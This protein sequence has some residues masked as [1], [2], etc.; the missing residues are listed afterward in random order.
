MMASISIALCC[1]L[2]QP[3]EAIRVADR[4]AEVQVI[5]AGWGIV[6]ITVT[7]IAESGD[8]RSARDS[9]SLVRRTWPEPVLRVRTTDANRVVSTAGL[10]VRVIGKPLSIRV[11]GREGRLIQHLLVDE[12]T[13][14]VRF[15][16]GHGP[17]LGLGQGGERF[18]RRGALWTMQA[19][20]K[21]FT[22][23]KRH[24]G[25]WMPVPYLIGTDGWAMF[26]DRPDVKID[27]RGDR[28]EVIPPAQM[29][30]SV[31]IFA[32]AVDEPAAA[33]RAY[34]ELT[35]FAALP[36]RWTMGYM[37]SHRTLSDADT[38]G[39]VAQNFRE[40]RL[41]CDVLIYLGTGFTRSGWNTG[42]GQFEW[43]GRVFPE[44]GEALRRLRALN[45]RVA[46]HVWPQSSD[47]TDG[48]TID[49]SKLQQQSTQREYWSLHQAANL[50]GLADGWW[51]DG[52]ESLP[53]AAR[54]GRHQMYHEQALEDYPDRR[55]WSLHRT[56][57]AGMQRYGGWLWTGDPYSEW[58]TLAGH[59][60]VGINAG[61]S[62]VPFWG[63]DIGGFHPTKEL[64]GELYVRWFQFGAF[65]PLFRSHGRTWHLRLPWGWNTGQYGPREAGNNDPLVVDP[66]PK[67]LRDPSVEAI[68]RDYL[69]LRYR[70]LPYNY[71]L[72]WQ[73]HKTGMPVIRAMWLHYPEDESAIG[74]GSQ[75]LWGRDLLIAPVTEQGATTRRL[76][77][78]EGQWHDWWTAESVDG[79]RWIER[80]VDRATMPIYARAGAIV[81]LDP[82]RQYTDQPVDAPTEVRVFPGA[83]GMMQWY[84][85]DGISM[86]YQRTGGTVLRLVW[87]DLD[88]QL[89]VS[90]EPDSAPLAHPKELRVHIIGQ[91]QTRDVTFVGD[92]LQIECLR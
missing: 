67:H 52:G 54:L 37:Q 46:L 23:G 18:D 92:D 91:M 16:L 70:L 82:V 34:A 5:E 53:A 39:W 3:G 55:P 19:M 28:G 17:V 27:L 41:P 43:N 90:V 20:H 32:I 57:A 49:F 21:D 33:M 86:E 44:P 31:D 65:C 12:R 25:G 68:C 15:L 11:T 24:Y 30:L 60:E 75:Y 69:N 2:S 26:V 22:A 87:N 36:P 58:K 40:R 56:G 29:P 14:H 81:P 88:Q 13:A 76:Y 7:P 74:L 50:E 63:H 64:T 8:S 61:L 71:S 48:R 79:G 1:L 47:S 51:P 4:L 80:D 42:H 89:R 85:D 66:D 73:A 78:P 9:S 45:F 10:T 72:A 62:G 59:V 83:D 84:D 38:P 77:L 35:G 6:R